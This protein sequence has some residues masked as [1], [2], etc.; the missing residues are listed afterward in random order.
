[1][2]PL[3]ALFQNGLQ[4][5]IYPWTSMSNSMQPFS[6][7]MFDDLV[8]NMFAVMPLEWSSIADARPD[9]RDVRASRHRSHGVI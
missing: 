6:S 9:K 4:N 1:M 8:K 5:Y 2:V 7:T 3:P